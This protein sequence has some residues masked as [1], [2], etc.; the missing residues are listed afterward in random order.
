MPTEAFVNRDG[1][2]LY[3]SVFCERLLTRSGEGGMGHSCCPARCHRIWTCATVGQSSCH[4]WDTILGQRTD[5]GHSSWHT[6]I[7]TPV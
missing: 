7:I 6:A 5:L 4:S 1:A 3:T 2:L